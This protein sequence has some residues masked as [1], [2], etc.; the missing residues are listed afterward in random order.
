MAR[1]I[2]EEPTPTSEV[3]RLD[4]LRINFGDEVPNIGCGNRAVLV[5]SLGPKWATLL[6]PASGAHTQMAREGWREGNH[7][8]HGFDELSRRAKVCEYEDSDMINRI[9]KNT[10]ANNSFSTVA[11]D[12]L[13]AMGCPDSRLPRRSEEEIEQAPKKERQPKVDK[14]AGLITVGE[15]AA[16]LKIDPKEARTSLRKQKTPKPAEGWAWS[17]DKVDEIKKTIIKGLKKDGKS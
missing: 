13:V 11:R 17:A 8:M 3:R 1:H 6:E 12:A 7:V 10:E 4:Y 15:I 14:K 5:V 16:Q 2:K 9:L